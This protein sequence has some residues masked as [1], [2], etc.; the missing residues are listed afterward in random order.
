MAEVVEHI[1]FCDLCGK[2]A[3]GQL[4]V[5]SQQ[6]QQIK[7][8]CVGVVLRGRANDTRCCFHRTA[9]W[10]SAQGAVAHRTYTTVTA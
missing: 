8:D 1:G 9:T 5:R 10:Y 2:E 6:Q 7:P 4:E 3:N